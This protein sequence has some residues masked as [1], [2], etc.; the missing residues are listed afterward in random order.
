MPICTNASDFRSTRAG[1]RYSFH[2]EM[3]SMIPNAASA[4]FEVGHH[5]LPQR[6]PRALPVHHRRVEQ[7]PGERLHVLAQQQHTEGG[8]QVGHHH[9]GD[10]VQQAVCETSR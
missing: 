7:F 3:N 5:H 1:Q 8:A 2:A 6:R 10:G 9:T 4:G